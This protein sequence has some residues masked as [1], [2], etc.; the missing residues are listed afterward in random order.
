MQ[1]HAGADHHVL[2]RKNTVYLR[3]PPKLAVSQCMGYLKGKSALMIFDKHPEYKG[4]N[5]LYFWARG[6]SVSTVGINKDDP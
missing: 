3:I 1:N 4:V 5:N 6:Y 2:I